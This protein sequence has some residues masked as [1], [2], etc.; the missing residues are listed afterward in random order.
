MPYQ[1]WQHSDY[2]KKQ[3][4]QN[5]HM[6]Q[7]A[8]EVPITALYGREAR[9][10]APPRLHRWQLP[11]AELLNEHREELDVAAQPEESQ[12]AVNRTSEFLRTQ[13]AKVEVARPAED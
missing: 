6:P 12:A 11:L 7:V 5:C 4:C 13:S 10:H 3:S 8:E 9:R 1:E 2:N